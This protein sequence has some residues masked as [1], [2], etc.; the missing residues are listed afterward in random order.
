MFPPEPLA[1]FRGGVPLAAAGHRARR[2]TST[3]TCSSS[4][5]LAAAL[6]AQQRGDLEPLRGAAR[7]H[8]ARARGGWCARCAPPRTRA[9][10]DDWRRVA[11]ASWSTRRRRTGPTRRGRSPTLA[12]AADRRASTGGWCS[13]GAAIDDDSP[14]EALHDLRKKGKELRY[15]LEFFAGLF[16]AGGRRADGQDAE[17]AAGHARALPG[18]RG[19]GG[20]LR[21]LGDEIA[22]REGGPAAL[23]AMGVLVDAPRPTSRPRARRVRR[24][25]RRVRRAQAPRARVQETFG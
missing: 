10:L 9:A 18:P 22:A 3:S 11:R 19:P 1:R 14:P 25:L 20:M 6:P 4:T 2:A 24:A 23:M 5:T 16:P 12:G 7:R 21:A 15:L 8:A 17:G 13:M